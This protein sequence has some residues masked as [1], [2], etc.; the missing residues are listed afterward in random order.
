MKASMLLLFV[1]L[2]KKNCVLCEVRS[3]VED[4]VQDLTTATS[5]VPCA[6]RAES[7]DKIGILNITT[8]NSLLVNQS[9][10]LLGYE[11]TS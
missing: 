9:T 1:F 5:L 10:L 6:V 4:T 8:S 2:M 7:E 11:E 3:E